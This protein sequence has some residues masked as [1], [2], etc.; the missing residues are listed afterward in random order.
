MAEYKF[1]EDLV[2]Q[3]HHLSSLL[4]ISVHVVP[5]NDE[6]RIAGHSVIT[7]LTFEIEDVI[8]DDHLIGKIADLK[9]KQLKVKVDATKYKIVTGAQDSSKTPVT[10]T[11]TLKAGDAELAVYLLDD[12]ANPTARSRFTFQIN[13]V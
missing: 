8:F 9:G 2:L 11:L 7:C 12:S 5:V 4:H 10:A 1:K 13:L 3:Q 6:I